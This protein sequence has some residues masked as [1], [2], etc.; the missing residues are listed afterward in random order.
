[1]SNQQCFIAKFKGHPAGKHPRVHRADEL[2]EAPPRMHF[3]R[4]VHEYV[5]NDWRGK[6]KTTTLWNFIAFLTA[7]RKHNSAQMSSER[8]LKV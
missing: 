3:T 1:M 5:T 6:I 7:M 2:N 4:N 8:V